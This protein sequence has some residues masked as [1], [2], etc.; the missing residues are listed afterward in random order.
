MYA[1]VN[2]KGKQYIV[3]EG[4]V[5]RLD[6]LSLEEG[7]EVELN[8]VLFISK[9]DNHQVGTPFIEKVK[10]LG[11]VVTEYRDKK[12]IAFTYRRRKSSSRKVGHR[13]TYSLVKIKSIIE[14]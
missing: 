14:K 5:I 6:K 8:E 1:I 10:V 4:D 13:Q 3:K 2:H 11:E 12:V 7:S 9:E